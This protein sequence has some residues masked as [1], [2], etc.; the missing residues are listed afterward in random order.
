MSHDERGAYTPPS[1]RLAFDPRE[2]VRAGPP[3]V[4][5][6]LSGLVLI[7]LIGGV[8]FLYRHGVRHP[9]AS[10]AE[11]G[12]P[13]GEMKTPAPPVAD[14]AST[15]LSVD[16]GPTNAAPT[17]APGPEQPLPRPSPAPVV[18]LAPAAAP[19]AVSAAAPPPPPP[20][21]TAAEAAQPARPLTIAGLADAAVSK[22]PP[23]PTAGVVA[24][25]KPPPAPAQAAAPVAGWVQIGAFSSPALAAKGWNDI[26]RL[27]PAAM[28]GKGREVRPVAAGDATLYRTYITGFPTRDAAEAFCGR[29]KAAGKSCFV[30]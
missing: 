28:A 1:D 16:R 11:V 19:Q 24:A 21:V 22:R 29:L 2:P 13:V 23:K 14:A 30:K 7:G 15:S 18:A 3:P 4:T 12:Q 25:T 8:A 5:L 27:A 10:P 17:F 26:A 20:R 6:I 9:G